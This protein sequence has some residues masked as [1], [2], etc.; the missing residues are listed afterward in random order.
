MTSLPQTISLI[1]CG[2]T[3]D[4]DYDSLTGELIFTQTCLP[5]LLAQANHTLDLQLHTVMQKDS[6]MM[7]DLD[8]EKLYQACLLTPHQRIIITHGTDT[9][10]ESAAY[11]AKHY[12]ALTGKTIILTGAMRPFK[13]G[14]SDAEF[15]LGTALMAVQLAKP[16]VYIAMNGRLFNA[17]QVNK[18]RQLGVFVVKPNS[19]TD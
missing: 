10:P 19:S 11:L 4:K 6:L 15:N 14:Q 16:Q 8:R 7:T 9:M 2:G 17:E 1:I 13:L 5:Q 18:D 12:S 3:L